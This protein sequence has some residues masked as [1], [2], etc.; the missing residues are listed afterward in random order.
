MIALFVYLIAVFFCFF[1]MFSYVG[2]L[3]RRGKDREDAEY[4]LKNRSF[5]PKE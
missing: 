1:V 3:K 2:Y 5:P 4:L